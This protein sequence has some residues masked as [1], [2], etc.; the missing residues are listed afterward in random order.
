MQAPA[1]ATLTLMAL[2]PLLAWRAYARFR[3]MVGRQRLSRIRPWITLM[4]FPVLLVLLTYAGRTHVD[5]LWW[6]AAGLVFG[7]GLG[8]YGLR[9]THF[10]PTR[11]GLFYTPNVHLG[12][13]LSLLFV[14]RIAYRLIEVY[15]LKT[16]ASPELADFVRSPLTLAAFGLLAGYY[17]CYAVGLMRWRYRVQAAKRLR[18]A[19]AKRD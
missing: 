10:E 12:I 17:I 3:R 6:L 19:S 15:A 8:V 4:I 11:Q 5:R 9:L 18:E 2:L 1:P 13:A 7:A 14:V 16:V